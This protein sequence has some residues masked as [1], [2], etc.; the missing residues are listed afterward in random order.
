MRLNLYLSEPLI[1]AGPGTPK[2]P[3]P[4]G[5]TQKPT[6]PNAPKAPGSPSPGPKP[7][8]VPGQAKQPSQPGSPGGGGGGA[9]SAVKKT[10]FPKSQYPDRPI[11]AIDETA[12]SWVLPE[13][14]N[15]KYGDKGAKPQQPEQGQGQAAPQGEGDVDSQGR[16]IL[17]RPG[18]PDHVDPYAKTHHSIPKDPVQQAANAQ[19]ER[20]NRKNALK[21][22]INQGP[23][24][25]EDKHVPLPLEDTS[26]MTPRAMVRMANIHNVGKRPEERDKFLQQFEAET[27][28]YT[29]EQHAELAASLYEDGNPLAQALA[30]KHAKKAKG[31][32][33]EK[34]LTAD[35][36]AELAAAET[37]P[38][39]VALHTNAANAKRKEES[40]KDK[41]LSGHAKDKQQAQAKEMLEQEGL[42]AKTSDATG[43][44][45]SERDRELRSKYV[46]GH[47]EKVAQ[48]TSAASA[49]KAKEMLEQEGLGAS[50]E[51]LPPWETAQDRE[52]REKYL[53]DY[54]KD[55]KAASEKQAM[56]QKL[57]AEGLGTD[58]TK[59][60]PQ[61]NIDYTKDVDAQLAEKEAADKL[62]EKYVAGAKKQDRRLELRKPELEA[63]DRA[64][65]RFSKDA[66]AHQ[67]SKA[68]YERAI[69][70]HQAALEE[71]EDTKKVLTDRIKETT[72]KL[73]DLKQKHKDALDSAHKD[74]LS[75]HERMI[76]EHKQ[77]TD[78]ALSTRQKDL[79]KLKGEIADLKSKKPDVPRPGKGASPEE[80]KEYAAKREAAK[81]DHEK[82]I[83]A[84]QKELESATSDLSSN[85]Q[86]A[87]QELDDLTAKFKAVKA[88]KNALKEHPD[89]RAA[90]KKLEDATNQIEGDKATLQDHNRLKPKK[91]NVP[92]PKG[93]EPR[94]PSNTQEH[95]ARNAHR[96]DAQSLA[97][98]IKSHIIDNENLSDDQRSELKDL[99]NE[100]L[101]HAN[102]EH[103][104]DKQHKYELRTLSQRARQL[105]AHTDHAEEAAKAA[106][107]EARVQA[108]EART[109]SSESRKQN[110]A[111][112]KAQEEE[113]KAPSNPMEHAQ[114]D[115]HRRRAHKMIQNIQS[116]LRHN[117]NMDPNTRKYLQD[118]IA[119]GGP[120]H[121]HMTLDKVPGKS[122]TK[123]LRDMQGSL[124]DFTSKPHPEDQPKKGEKRSIASAVASGA[125]VGSQIESATGGSGAGLVGA[126]M[127]AVK[128]GIMA[129]GHHLL[130][131]K[132]DNAPANDKQSRYAYNPAKPSAPTTSSAPAA[133]KDVSDTVSSDVPTAPPPKDEKKSELISQVKKSLLTEELKR[134]SLKL[135]LQTVSSHLK[136]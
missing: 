129:A 37:N 33:P 84:K 75:E 26:K 43:P 131:G 91:P 111:E 73:K 52:M 133:T 51:K 118:M 85:K 9:S 1:K 48:E 80:M 8:S 59:N 94:K 32:D 60:Y 117:R 58:K 5:S 3:K 69:E 28:N 68:A 4:P 40:L 44:T 49:P 130:S 99:Y 24:G 19:Q 72:G 120:L 106:E 36:H 83:A 30:E 10:Y 61:N 135:K 78:A 92:A 29:P 100:A 35:Q 124:K 56:D 66:Q 11:N 114:V 2:P 101:T 88:D 41:Y 108:R 38:A 95:T 47:K 74:I 55:K 77:K 70:S 136:G 42:G 12:A 62:R 115:S 21:N 128:H 132:K 65:A 90:A 17:A 79:D 13:G 97:D 109:Q 98:K 76:S 102:L 134:V 122:H 22:K 20:I 87:K 121:Q 125:K 27:A 89:V 82:T 126:T 103:V 39:L 107:K 57:E 123:E 71:H 16:Q 25:E 96:H 81:S 7:A 14:Q 46:P 127:N 15:P 113:P 34:D 116:H 119:D 45:E 18:T 64:E 112:E 53:P 23:F 50:D 86:K 67:Q 104:P 31:I 110:K 54:N 6:M 63:P 93:S 105:G